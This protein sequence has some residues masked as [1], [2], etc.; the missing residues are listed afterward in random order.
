MRPQK[1]KINKNQQNKRRILGD[2]H[3]LEIWLQDSFQQFLLFVT[4]SDYFVFIEI[5][6]AV[7]QI[8]TSEKSLVAATEAN[9]VYSMCVA[10]KPSE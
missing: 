7:G 4:L 1:I 3:I 9:K 2:K 10:L 5:K 6:N 8:L